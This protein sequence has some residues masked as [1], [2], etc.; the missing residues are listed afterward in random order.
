[1]GGFQ[2]E[3]RGE[4]RIAVYI[5]DC[6]LHIMCNPQES[7]SLLINML[8]LYCEA[9][10]LKANLAML[11]FVPVRVDVKSGLEPDRVEEVPCGGLRASLSGELVFWQRYGEALCDACAGSCGFRGPGRTVVALTGYRSLPPGEL[12]GVGLVAVCLLRVP[13]RVCGG[14]SE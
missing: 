12:G 11:F 13:C 5:H 6:R 1:M 4:D 3:G 9:S 8:D 2:W 14:P 7:G 10:G